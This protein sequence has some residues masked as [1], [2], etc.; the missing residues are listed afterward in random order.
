MWRWTEAISGNSSLEHDSALN[1]HVY[2]YI[3][4]YY[5]AA[6]WRLLSQFVKTFVF[7]NIMTTYHTFS[8]M[9]WQTGDHISSGGSRWPDRSDSWP[10]AWCPRQQGTGSWA[11]RLHREAE[12][13][14]RPAA[15]R[16]QCS[17]V[18]AW[19]GQQQLH[20]APSEA[21]GDQQA[22]G[23]QGQSTPSADL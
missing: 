23:W 8:C 20:R 9:Q 4:E 14:E 2:N 7:L 19:S 21:G 12:Q 16:E 13:Q 5:A 22:A 11:S 10:P 1:I 15:V 3:N 18:A 6:N 17:A